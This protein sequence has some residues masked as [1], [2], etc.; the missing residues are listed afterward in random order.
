VVY[1]GL[2]I[3][4]RVKARDTAVSS[5]PATLLSLVTGPCTRAGSVELRVLDG[6]S[7]VLKAGTATLVIGA[8]G[9]GKS[10]FLR[11]LTG[12]LAVDDPKAIT[13]NGQTPAQ[14]RGVASLPRLTS[15]CPQQDI[16]EPMLTVKETL[17]FAHA[18]SI[19]PLPATATAAE[20]EARAK[21]VDHVI[22]RLGMHE[23]ANTIVGN[24]Q[25]RGISGGQKRRLTIGE[26]LVS[27]SRLLALDGQ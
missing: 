27:G 17:T 4:R 21:E 6:I 12:R 3:T 26:S 5:V 20:R 7:G 14:L 10:A 13:Y 18:T 23:C 11:A 25:V 22:D 24:S 9:S 8:P 2:S 19:A 15:Y 1:R 16:H